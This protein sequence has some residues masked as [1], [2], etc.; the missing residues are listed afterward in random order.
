M[1]GWMTRAEVAEAI[2]VTPATL[3]RW[4]HQRIG[5]P[6]LRL[7]RQVYYRA[8]AFRAWLVARETGAPEAAGAS[9]RVR[10]RR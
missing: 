7:G 1:T 3:Q 9:R 10:G 2:G 4:D 5:P 8:E 6:T